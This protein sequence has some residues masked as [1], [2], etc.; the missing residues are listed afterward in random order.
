MSV[1]KKKLTQKEGFPRQQFSGESISIV[2]F[3]KKY[4]VSEVINK[5]HEVDEIEKIDSQEKNNVLL[6][7]GVGSVVLLILILFS[8]IGRKKK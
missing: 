1:L 6:K 8:V 4:S 7:S 5:Q 3:R 2:P